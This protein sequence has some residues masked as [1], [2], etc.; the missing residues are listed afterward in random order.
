MDPSKFLTDLSRKSDL[1]LALANHEYSWPDL[2]G[3]IIVLTGMGSSLYAAKSFATLLQSAG[4]SAYA[5]Y[6]SN[7]KLFMGSKKH[8]LIAI[9]ATGRSVETITAFN[10]M[11]NFRDKFWLTNETCNGDNNVLMNAGTE[12][13]GIA[14]LSYLATNIS[15]LK[16]AHSLGV[17]SECT[18]SIRQ[19]GYAIEEIFTS[20]DQWL[21]EFLPIVSSNTGI[22]FIA[23]A[24]RVTSAEQSALMIREIPRL[25]AVACETGDWSH[26]DV[27]LTKS[28]DYRAVLFPGSSWDSALF[29]WTSERNSKIV[30]VGYS[31]ANS[32]KSFRYNG[33]QDPIVRLLAETTYAEVL[34]NSLLGKSKW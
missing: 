19:A 23:P 9:S 10:N 8:S 12:T 34:A 26:V 25:P 30:T 3:Q 5:T 4:I 2:R 13:S 21:P 28:Q 27:Y 7:S 22:N 29:K 16:L 18:E 11:S 24:D 17:I 32:T 14:A 15:L 31:D 33:D 1:T 20:R 6:A